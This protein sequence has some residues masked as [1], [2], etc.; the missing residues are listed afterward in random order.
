MINTIRFG[1]RKYHQEFLSGIAYLFMY[2]PI[3]VWMW[4]RWW[5]RD[6]YY[7]HGILIPMVT[8]YLIWQK[9]DELRHIPRESSKVGI[10]WVALGV[11]VFFFSSF[12]RIYFIA[13]FTMIIVLSGLILGF[14]GKKILYQILF[15][16]F[17]LAFM[18]PLPEILITEISFSMK[19][20][21]AQVAT[22]ILNHFLHL[23]AL[24]EGSLIKMMHAYVMVDDVCSGLR[25][26]M[27]LTALGSLFA[28]WLKGPWYK[29]I[30]L[31]LSTIPI[32]IMTNVFRIVALSSINEIW[33]TRYITGFL[34]TAS[35]F[36]VFA[37]A[38]LLLW[39]ITK[40]LE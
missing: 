23:S 5:A 37:L 39:T 29:K 22:Y 9:R 14:F 34:H 3:L 21:A 4:D 11:F 24:R 13:G 40:I 6:S 28:Y 12:L 31:F 38:F 17:F 25:S 10:L 15:P 20:F 26:L 27:S 30:L 35:G 18:T 1:F 32:A 33:G 8:A 36:M 2:T 7:S 16:I 19:I